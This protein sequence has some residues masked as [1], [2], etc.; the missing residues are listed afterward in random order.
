V[1]QPE[2]SQY[3]FNLAVLYTTKLNE[4]TKALRHCRTA[5]KLDPEN[6]KALHLM[7]NILQELG[8]EDEAQSYFLHAETIAQQQS[9]SQSIDKQQ[10]T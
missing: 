4:H 2:N 3:Q 10:T 7:G 6:I 5:L 8:Q 9:Q 1:K